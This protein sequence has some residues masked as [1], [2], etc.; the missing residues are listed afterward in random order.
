MK[1]PSGWDFVPRSR[2]LE[3]P[4]RGHGPLRR[5]YDVSVNLLTGNPIPTTDTRLRHPVRSGLRGAYDAS[6]RPLPIRARATGTACI[7]MGVRGRTPIRMPHMTR[8][9]P[10]VDPARSVVDGLSIC[11][12]VFN[13]EAAVAET[14]TRCLA[15]GDDLRSAGVRQFEVIAVDDGSQDRTAEIIRQHPQVRLIQ[16]PRNAGYGAALK[17]GFAAAR[18]ELI[19]FLDADATYPPECLPDLCAPLV[20]H[21]ADL[22]VGSRMAGAQSEMPAIRRLGN[23]VF[24]RLLSIMSRAQVSDSASGMRVFRRDLL[25]TLSPLPDGLNLTPVMSTRALHE[26]ITVMELPIPYAERLGQSK[27]HVA[28]DG[29]RFL[30][31]M[32]EATL[33]YNPVRIFGL[34]GIL[35]L[36]VAGAIFAATVMARLQGVTVLGPVATFAV[37]AAMVSAVAGVSLFALGANFNYL[38]SL[39]YNRPIRQGLFREPLFRRPIEGLFLPAGAAIGAAGAAAASISLLLSF[40]GWPIE[41]LWLYLSASGMCA[42]MGLQL[43]LWGVMA[44]VL[45]ELSQR[46]VTGPESGQGRRHE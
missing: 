37:F 14:L 45:R 19:G 29:M 6:S 24:A 4:A 20:D 30:G 33:A 7:G 11:I 2:G 15:L 41:R 40:K 35:A 25:R 8:T 1:L 17:T 42:L 21:R 28:R 18:F 36:G 43:A 44:D 22:V 10:A 32:V 38:V 27:L 3:T 13:E 23:T 16:H 12:P 46:R 31:T 39:F 9:R 5:T 34:A 26:G